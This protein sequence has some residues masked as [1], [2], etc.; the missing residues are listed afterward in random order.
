MHE[1]QRGHYPRYPDVTWDLAEE[2]YLNA[3]GRSEYLGAYCYSC[4]WNLSEPW[5]VLAT[6]ERRLV[7]EIQAAVAHAYSCPAQLSFHYYGSGSLIELQRPRRPITWGRWKVHK[8]RPKADAPG[9][10]VL[11]TF[12]PGQAVRP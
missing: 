2:R 3:Q 8:K 4:D 5:Q 12:G 6:P 9:I 7:A 1:H 11:G 10:T